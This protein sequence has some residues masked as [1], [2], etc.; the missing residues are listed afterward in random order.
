MCACRQK[1][2]V[3]PLPVCVCDVS[4]STSPVGSASA[5][6][7]MNDAHTAGWAWGLEGATRFTGSGALNLSTQPNVVVL[8]HALEAVGLK[9]RLVDTPSCLAPCS[10]SDELLLH[11][12]T[13]TYASG[14]G[15]QEA[16]GA[17]REG[18]ESAARCALLTPH[19]EVF[20]HFRYY[21]KRRRVIPVSVGLVA[22]R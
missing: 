14:G 18:A 20:H 16:L 17:G 21:H 12:G 15:D 8:C 4:C 5:C 22:E 9:G 1:V 19:V 3:S 6:S 11:F 7:D 10:H 13:R 2:H